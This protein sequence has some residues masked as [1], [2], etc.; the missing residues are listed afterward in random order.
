MRSAPSG[1]STDEIRECPYNSGSV[2]RGDER[3]VG[4]GGGSADSQRGG[5]AASSASEL[6]SDGHASGFMAQARLQTQGGLLSLGGGPGFL[7]GY[8]G[9]S[10]ALGLGLGLTRFGISSAEDGDVSGSLTLFQSCRRLSSMSGNLRTVGH[11]QI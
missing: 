11:A 1:G 7:L 10:Y 3:R 6:R 9:G 4:A 2:V 5:S 8:Q